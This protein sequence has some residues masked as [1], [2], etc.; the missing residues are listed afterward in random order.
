M[1]IMNEIEN[2]S[3][4]EFLF[5]FLDRADSD[6]ISLLG[7]K[8]NEFPIASVSSET[9][10][11]EMRP[12][13]KKESLFNETAFCTANNDPA[14][15]IYSSVSSFNP[16][17]GSLNS[18]SA[19]CCFDDIQEYTAQ[20]Y[21][22]PISSVID[23]DNQELIGQIMNVNDIGYNFLDPNYKDENQTETENKE[24]INSIEKMIK[25]M[26][27]SQEINFIENPELETK[28]DNNK[29]NYK[30]ITPKLTM[31]KF[32]PIIKPSKTRNLNLN[33]G[34]ITKNKSATQSQPILVGN[35]NGSGLNLSNKVHSNYEILSVHTSPTVQAVS[36][37]KAALIIS[38]M[39]TNS[40][41]KGIPS[42]NPSQSNNIDS[43]SLKKQ[44]RMI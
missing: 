28:R 39:L 26:D 5:D 1:N 27:K 24:L 44:S 32:E 11:T 15:G 6:D 18:S 14:C 16:E 41:D 25:S 13:E 43:S 34:E 3:P 22:S 29:L 40:V 42:T 10:T 35:F 2:V 23:L 9:L 7:P 4:N 17:K 38:P 8:L 20:L 30:K 21:P 37:P 19:A 36:L 31:N 12:S 33:S